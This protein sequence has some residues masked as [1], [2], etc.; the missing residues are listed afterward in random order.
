MSML[1]SY[2]GLVKD[3]I[4]IIYVCPKNENIRFAY[5][6]FWGRRNYHDTT[7]DN[8]V[9]PTGKNILGLF[10]IVK[11]RDGAK[12]FKLAT[13]HGEI[14]DFDLYERLFGRLQK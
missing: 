12:T 13:R 14:S 11:L 1:W 6:D 2:S 8:I 4:G 5:L 7:I 9:K 10:Q 3:T